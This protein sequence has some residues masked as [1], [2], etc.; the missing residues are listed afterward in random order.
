MSPI[1]TRR[2]NSQSRRV[3]IR[4]DQKIAMFSASASRRAGSPAESGLP[5]ARASRY[6]DSSPHSLDEGLALFHF[7]RGLKLTKADLAIDFRR[8]QPRAFVSH[9]HADHMARHEFALCTPAT[10]RLYQL[11]FGKRATRELPYRNSIE[12][13]SLKLSTYPAGHCLGSA[14]LLAEEAGQR[15]L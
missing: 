7:D 5:R 13:G 1:P 14:M 9:A 11:R 15:L 6:D 8:R 12:W 3:S 2:Q 10:S 4:G